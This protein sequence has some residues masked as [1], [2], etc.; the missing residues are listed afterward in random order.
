MFHDSDTA[1]VRIGRR[2][3]A[4]FDHVTRQLWCRIDLWTRT[5]DIDAMLQ[6]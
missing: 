2:R 1:K 4:F 6:M 3:K 5:I